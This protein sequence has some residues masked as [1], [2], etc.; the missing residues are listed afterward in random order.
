MLR[1]KVLFRGEL[2]I[3]LG[4]RSVRLLYT[5][6]HSEDHVSAFIEDRRILIAGAVLVN[7]MIPAFM[8]GDSRVLESTLERLKEL[9]IEGL[10]PGHGTFIEGAA[11]VRSALQWTID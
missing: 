7:A 1:P 4:D 6:G 11:N 8:D 9:P 2:R 3:D 5:P 10:L